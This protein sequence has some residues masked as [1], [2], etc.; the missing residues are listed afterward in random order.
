MY[1]KIYMLGPPMVHWIFREIYRRHVITVDHRG[2]VDENM[3]LS[4]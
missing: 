3:E 1:V 4:K 2:F